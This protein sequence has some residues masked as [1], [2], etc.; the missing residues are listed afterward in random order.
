MSP[1]NK[2]NI[3][4]E[5]LSR[6]DFNS[7]YQSQLGNLGKI[8]SNGWSEALL[9]P[10]H[11]EQK[12]SMGVNIISGQFNCFGCGAKGSIF[13]FHMKKYDIDFKTSLSELAKIAGI[14]LSIPQFPQSNTNSYKN[15][16]FEELFNISISMPFPE[17]GKIYLKEKRKFSNEIISFLIMNKLI[18]WNEKAWFSPGNLKPAI[19]FPLHDHNGKMVGL[20]NIF[21]DGSGKKFVSKSKL[22]KAFFKIGTDDNTTIITE[23][24]IDAISAIQATTNISAIA[25]LSANSLEKLKYLKIKKPI[26]FFDNDEAGRKA[27]LKAAE[28][29]NSYLNVKPKTVKWE[30]KLKDINEL[31]QQGFPASIT[32]MIQ[33]AIELESTERDREITELNMEINN[34]NKNYAV[35]MVG[36]DTVVMY[37]FFEPIAEKTDI[38]FLSFSAFRNKFLNQKIINPYRK[39]NASKYRDIGS[40]WL[41]SKKRREYEQCVFDPTEKINTKKYYNLFRGFSVKPIKGDWSILRNHIYEIICNGNKIMDNWL[42]SWMARIIQN[43]GGERPGTAVVF[44]GE[45]GSGKGCLVNAL[46]KLMHRHFL[47]ITQ[48]KHL[49]GN[50]NS[51]LKDALLVFADEVTWGGDKQAEGILKGLIT[52]PYFMLEQKNKDAFKVKSHVNLM[53]SSNNDWIIP[54][55]LQERRFFTLAVNNS[56]VG[57]REYFN[58]L[59]KQISLK[60]ALEAMMYDLL[61]YNINIDLRTIP[62]TD[63][64]LQQIINSMHPVHK[65]W[66]DRLQ[67]GMLLFTHD[68]WEIEVERVEF[69]NEYITFCDTIHVTYK[70]PLNQFSRKLKEICPSINLI[71]PRINGKQTPMYK[72]VYL[73]ACREEFENIVKIKVNWE[74][75]TNDISYS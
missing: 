44:K 20:Q 9:C 36:S 34:L 70:L 11:D 41:E 71:R 63:E 13:N 1:V 72:F 33:N 61:N 37:E 7:Y 69:Y 32:N 40:L 54:A 59:H 21:I 43:P 3:K 68:S 29:L 17:K 45:Q 25:T 8:K 30:S 27:T 31:L 16:S 75:N 64:L 62:R 57:D 6:L 55:G 24:I 18:G 4:N 48:P 53:I 56:K 74:Q 60:Q 42:M 73:E 5:I 23:A 51:H 35:T 10:F 65:F 50:F 12:P 38:K 15:L 52:E 39:P 49:T 22:K 67:Y 58:K 47:P 46:G 66:Y 28:I 26:I 19:V 14:E 2:L